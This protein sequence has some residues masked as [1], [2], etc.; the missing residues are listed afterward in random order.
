MAR[1]QNAD[2]QD[3]R[4]LLHEVRNV[5]ATALTRAHE[6]AGSRA[7][8]AESCAVLRQTVIYLIAEAERF[9][10]AEAEGVATPTE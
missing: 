5:Q 6:V 8:L 10:D 9:M 1:T 2:E 4:R 7:R 3:L